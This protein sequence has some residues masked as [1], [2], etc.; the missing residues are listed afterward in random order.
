ME[1]FRRDF[2]H[3]RV[4]IPLITVFVTVSQDLTNVHGKLI[5]RQN[6]D[7][8]KLLILYKVLVQSQLLGSARI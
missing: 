6:Y 8:P 3:Y 2:G 1:N 4:L 7:H 5:R